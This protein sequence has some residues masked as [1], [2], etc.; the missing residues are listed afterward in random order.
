TENRPTQEYPSHC[1]KETPV[2]LAGSGGG[3]RQPLV[4]DRFRGILLASFEFVL[5]RSNS[6]GFVTLRLYSSAFA[7][8]TG[9]E[10]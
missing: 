9:A 1:K 4:I 10:A 3:T 2:P 6:F 5:V 7:W 8:L